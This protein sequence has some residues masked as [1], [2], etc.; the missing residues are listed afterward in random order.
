MTRTHAEGGGG[1]K[2]RYEKFCNGYTFLSFFLLILSFAF[3]LTIILKSCIVWVQTTLYSTTCLRQILGFKL[4]DFRSLFSAL[5]ARVGTV[6]SDRG[7]ETSPDL[8]ISTSCAICVQRMWVSAV[9][10]SHV[11]IFWFGWM[12]AFKFFLVRSS[13]FLRGY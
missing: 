13:V 9:R 10:V 5:P 8:G 6:C 7:I 2:F 4:G 3:R 11:V 1:V 12:S